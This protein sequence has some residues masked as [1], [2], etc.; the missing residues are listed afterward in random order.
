M[1]LNTMRRSSIGLAT[2]IILSFSACV[3][4]FRHW[5]I[6]QVPKKPALT[7]VKS[8]LKA[9]MLDG[10]VVVFRYGAQISE[11]EVTGSGTVSGLRGERRSV[12]A[13]PLDSIVGMESFDIRTEAGKSLLVSTAATGVG[14][15]AMVGAMI[16]IFGSCPTYYV[17]S[18][19]VKVLQG[20]GFSYSIAPLFEQ[21]DVDRLPGLT[22][23]NSKVQVE[24]R[25]E[26]LETHYLN[27][28]E[29]LDIEH[30]PGTSVVV[31]SRLGPV[32]LEEFS[33]LTGARDR[34]GRNILPVLGRTDGNV[35]A[36]EP[37]IL[38]SASERDLDDYLD[39]EVPN[40]SGADSV[41]IELRLRNS[42]LNTVLLYDG[43]LASQG[44]EAFNWLQETQKITRA[45]GLGRWYSAHMGMRVQ[46]EQGG[47]YKQVAR[48]NDK[49]PI[50]FDNVAVI[51][52]TGGS[53]SVRVRLQFPADNWRIDGVRVA[54]KYSYAKV[55]TVRLTEVLR[56]D[57]TPDTQAR[58]RLDA[59]DEQ[60]LVTSPG[61][62][63]TASFNIGAPGSSSHTFMLASQGY[64]T[65]WMRSDWLKKSAAQSFVLNDA[66]LAK[67]ITTWRDKQQVFEA[68]FYSTQIPVR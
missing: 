45:I 51:I 62:V 7:A 19:G 61:Q 20:E 1:A 33:P 29:L 39:I 54:Q 23:K 68:Q 31:D 25:N 67:A 32:I 35:Y 50:A 38:A 21:R 60:Y 24:I 66:S 48:I 15:V 26:A 37:G 34:A 52:P 55:R 6:Q 57:G 28:L 10:S 11:S 2:A 4:I 41:A 56:D 59:P 65:E 40:T 58:K 17:D 14:V 46:V 3:N 13:V 12:Q 16:A 63:F 5:E 36:T 30:R 44:A 53:R 18:A 49:G 42:L 8:P 22:T 64:Y 9:H 47:A 43:M 27:H